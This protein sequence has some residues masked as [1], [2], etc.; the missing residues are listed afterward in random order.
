MNSL[1][2]QILS[3]ELILN[4]G[5]PLNLI[6]Q[7]KLSKLKLYSGSEVA[8]GN[9]KL[10]IENFILDQLLDSDIIKKGLNLSFNYNKFKLKD[11][12]CSA[13]QKRDQ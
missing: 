4:E 13:P 1:N 7:N 9:K 3:K 5:K 11:I 10:S 6:H 2:R 12:A 8:N